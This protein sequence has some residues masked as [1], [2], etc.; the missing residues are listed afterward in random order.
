MKENYTVCRC[1]QVTYAEIADA[2]EQ[3]TQFSDVLKAFERVQEI[4][5]C[6]TGC[7]SC[8]DKI[9]AIISDVLMGHDP[10]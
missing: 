2:L 5:H 4:T 7:G 6:S 10:L 9:M 8:H 3:N 1:K